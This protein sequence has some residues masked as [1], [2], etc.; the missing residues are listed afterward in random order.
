MVSISLPSLIRFIPSAAKPFLR[1]GIVPQELV[2]TPLMLSVLTLAY[3]GKPI[4][5]FLAADSLETQQRQVFTTYV[6]RMLQRRGPSL[7][8]LPQQTIHWLAWLARRIAL[9]EQTE[10]YIERMQPS[11]LLEDLSHSAYYVSVCLV[12]GL[13]AGLPSGLLIGL[14]TG[15][16][17]GLLSGLLVGLLGILIIKPGENIEPAEVVTWR[18]Y[19]GYVPKG[20]LLSLVNWLV[21]GLTSGLVGWLTSEPVG[22]LDFGSGIGLLIGPLVYMLIILLIFSII[23]IVLYRGGLL[24]DQCIFRVTLVGL[25]L[26]VTWLFIG[27]P[28]GLVVGL[29]TMLYGMQVGIQIT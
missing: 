2:A 7:R 15:P 23:L 8:Y 17:S 4:E 20:P 5:D 24:R 22:W 13:V 9:D 16:I 10:F 25:M 29:L 6:Q 11:W 26:L 19:W 1:D 14:I 3:H 18:F 27:L 28:S 12:L 21:I